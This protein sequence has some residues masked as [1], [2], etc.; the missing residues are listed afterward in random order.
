MSV[1]EPFDYKTTKTEPGRGACER[2]AYLYDFAPIGYVTLDSRGMILDINPTGASMLGAEGSQLPGK[3]F[4]SF[5]IQENHSYF[6]KQLKHAFTSSDKR[7]TELKIKGNGSGLKD[8][9][10]EN[11][12][13]FS[14][15]GAVAATCCLAMLD[16]SDYKRTEEALLYNIRECK[17]LRSE[18]AG[19]RSVEEKLK[20]TDI[21]LESAKAQAETAN[22]IKA[23][24]L[25]NMFHELRMQLTYIIESSEILYNDL[26]GPVTDKQKDYVTDIAGKGRRLLSLINSIL[27]KRA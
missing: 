9:R 17:K 2:D 6:L 26:T 1:D 7:A 4:S 13:G 19:L 15:N 16:I 11:I 18:L 25:A 27:G 5:V 22:M 8:L 23:E 20:R 21:E 12:S 14:R 10:L 3:Y 24:S